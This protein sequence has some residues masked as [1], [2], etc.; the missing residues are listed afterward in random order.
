[1]EYN[2]NT[3]LT[4]T[5]S[6]CDALGLGETHR[7]NNTGEICIMEFA[8]V[9]AIPAEVAAVMLATYT[10]EQALALVATEEWVSEMPF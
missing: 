9:D 4:I 2:S 6:D 10:H 5:H 3:Y 7:T 8:S 1:M